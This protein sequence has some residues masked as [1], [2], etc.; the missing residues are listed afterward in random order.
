MGQQNR[1]MSNIYYLNAPHVC[2]W[3]PLELLLERFHWSINKRGSQSK[4]TDFGV[5]LIFYIISVKFAKYLRIL[6]SIYKEFGP[7]LSLV[8]IL[9]RISEFFVLQKFYRFIPVIKNMFVWNTV[10]NFVSFQLDKLMKRIR[11]LVTHFAVGSPNCTSNFA[12]NPI[13]F[14]D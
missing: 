4:I 8:D 2:Q 12:T 14:A 11:C 1:S 6:C 7:C 13:P 9:F 5:Y 10:C 3:F